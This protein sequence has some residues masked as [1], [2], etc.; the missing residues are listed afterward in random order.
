M[1]DI[2]HHLI[3]DLDDGPRDLETSCAMIDAAIDNGFTHI[4]ATPHANDRW[5]YLPDVNRERL[6]EIEAY[7]AGRI[8]LGL[9]CDFHLS[10][11]NIQDQFANPAKYSINNLRYLL[12]EFP[13]YGI[14]PSIGET[15]YEFVAS[16]VVPILTHPERNATL[17]AKP[18][19]MADWI[20]NGCVVQVTAGALLGKFGSKAEAAAHLLLQRNWVHFLA[21]DAHNLTSRPPN[22]GDGHQVLAKDYG[23]EVA[24]RLCIE[25]PKAVFYGK[26]LPPQ[27]EPL[28]L[29]DEVEVKG[30]GLL[31]RIFSRQ[32]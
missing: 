17:Q 9:G 26:P 28:G 30:K 7:A 18:E 14:Q 10:Y 8:T 6:A 31:S 27:P 3:Y 23:Q 19:M 24:D 25:N 5:A 20:R 4:V 29:V 22:L 15:L 13:D 12:V 11:D 2:H 16:G 32:G 21:S 1:I